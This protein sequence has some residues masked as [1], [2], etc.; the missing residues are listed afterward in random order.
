MES[1]TISVEKMEFIGEMINEV[2]S[3]I[4][5]SFQST[6]ETDVRNTLTK[7]SFVTGSLV[8]EL[9]NLQ[10]V[11]MESSSDNPVGFTTK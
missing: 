8:T 1:V 7:I 9:N 10:N 3:A 5:D 2:S 4:H 6:S 11:F